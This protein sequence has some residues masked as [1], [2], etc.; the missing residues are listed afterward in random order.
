MSESYGHKAMES[1]QWVVGD[2]DKVMQSLAQKIL[3]TPKVDDCGR[4][5]QLLSVRTTNLIAI[6]AELGME[7]QFRNQPLMYKLGQ[8]LPFHLALRWGD[9]CNAHQGN[10]LDLK[11]F[12]A[13]LKRDLR[14]SLLVGQNQ[15][16]LAS[17]EDP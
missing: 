10:L 6:L 17:T 4:G 5:L 9:Y 11:V 8:K 1:R 14:L 3:A 12:D 2:P 15:V 16:R 7:E 13:F